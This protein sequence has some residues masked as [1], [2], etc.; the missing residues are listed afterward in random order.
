MGFG[1]EFEATGVDGVHR[2]EKEPLA[3]FK[4]PPRNFNMTARLEKH[5]GRKQVRY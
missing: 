1:G 4:P 2:G 5:C 3:F